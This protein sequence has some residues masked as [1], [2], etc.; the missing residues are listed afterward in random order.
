MSAFC[1]TACRIQKK[2]IKVL[3]DI[4]QTTQEN[5]IKDTTYATQLTNLQESDDDTLELDF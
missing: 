5:E 2:E 4:A 3:R 1:P